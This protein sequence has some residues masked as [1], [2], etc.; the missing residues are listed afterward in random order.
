MQTIP[1]I[2]FKQLI[3]DEL[4]KAKLFDA[5]WFAGQLWRIENMYNCGETPCG[6]VDMIM[7]FAKAQCGGNYFKYPT[8]ADMEKVGCTLTKIE[9]N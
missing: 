3:S 7:T 6:A 4:I 9:V 8:M 5:K 2:H 1:Y